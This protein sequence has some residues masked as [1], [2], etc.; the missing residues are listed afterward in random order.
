MSRVAPGILSPMCLDCMKGHPHGINKHIPFNQEGGTVI[1]HLRSDR[2][3]RITDILTWGTNNCTID[4]ITIDNYTQ[5]IGAVPGYAFAA[6]LRR[7][8]IGLDDPGKPTE[9]QVTIELINQWLTD[10]TVEAHYVM[11]S[12]I[13]IDLSTMKTASELQLTVTGHLKD[14]VFWGHRILESPLN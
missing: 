5:M 9:E 1:Y 7:K 14:L 10:Y 8:D 11:C 12:R 4:D 3:F 2:P 13:K 6:P